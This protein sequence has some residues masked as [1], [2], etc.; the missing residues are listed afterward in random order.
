MI[1][2]FVNT[3]A[4]RMRVHEELPF[5]VL[6]SDVRR[7]ALEAY[8][9]HD[10]PFEQVVA[11]L[12]PEQRFD[13]S[14]IVQTAFLFQEA[15][16]DPRRIP[17]LV[18]EPFHEAGRPRVHFDLEVK[19]FDDRQRICITW[20]YRRD[21]FDAESMDDM[22]RSLY[23]VARSDRHVTAAAA[24]GRVPHTEGIQRGL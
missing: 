18:L 2:C 16:P 20:W 11:A 15:S 1:G 9:H 10:V 4:L 14:P 23:L 5:G 12:A 3:V 19:A 17:G 6:L 22:L 8:R 21:L 24:P 7:T 13:R